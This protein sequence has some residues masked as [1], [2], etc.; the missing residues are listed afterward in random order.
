MAGPER[1]DRRAPCP[2]DQGPALADPTRLRQ[3]RSSRAPTGA[4][5]IDRRYCV[6]AR[7]RQ[8]VPQP[9]LVVPRCA[10]SP[11]SPIRD[12]RRVVD[13]ETSLSR[14][15]RSAWTASRPT[16][17]STPGARIS[18]TQTAPTAARQTTATRSSTATA[19]HQLMRSTERNAGHVQPRWLHRLGRVPLPLGRRRRLHL[20]SLPSLALRRPERGRLQASSSGAG[21]WRVSPVRF[22][23]RSCTS[24]RQRWLL[25]ARSCSTTPSSTTI[26]SR[27]ATAPPGTSPSRSNDE[28]RASPS[29]AASSD[30]ASASCPISPSKPSVRST[31]A[32]R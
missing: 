8:A 32:S 3:P 11:T 19:Y 1:Y 10:S 4:T 14:S 26:A 7:R 17:A 25:S 5:L 22:R 18:A 16:A 23:R 21:T 15:K 9:R 28:Q 20:G 13:R 29:S 30:C 6:H 12:A 2:R 27:A 31:T 24:A